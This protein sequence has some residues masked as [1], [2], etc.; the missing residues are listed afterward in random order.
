MPRARDR[1]FEQDCVV[2][3]GRQGFALGRSESSVEYIEVLEDAQTASSAACARLDH[4]RRCDAL[5]FVPEPFE[6]LLVAVVTG[7]D[8]NAEREGAAPRVDFAADGD[9]RGRRR[10]DEDEPRVND[11]LRE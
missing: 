9:H 1:A 4:E 7:N 10:T 5:C 3:E 11:G 6:R 8:R 2:A